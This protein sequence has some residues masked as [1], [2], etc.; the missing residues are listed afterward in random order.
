MR[1]LDTLLDE[2]KSTPWSQTKSETLANQLLEVAE[3]F[4]IQGDVLASETAYHMG[5]TPTS[6]WFEVIFPSVWG[7]LSTAAF[8]NSP[9]KKDIS[10]GQLP[11]IVPKADKLL[12]NYPVVSLVPSNNFQRL[13]LPGFSGY[14]FFIAM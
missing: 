6:V 10:L 12:G 7:L 13:F 11:T 14:L 4:Y 1:A 9:D 5:V 8:L 3:S 2:E